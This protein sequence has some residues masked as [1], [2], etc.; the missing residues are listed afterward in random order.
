VQ[1][2]FPTT[3]GQCCY[4]IPIDAA[5]IPLVSA[6]LDKFQIRHVWASAA[7]YEAGYNAFAELQADMSG[8]CIEQLIVEI[9]ALRGG[10]APALNWRDPD[11]DPANI[12]LSTLGGVVVETANVG[13]K[14]VLAN[15]KL[16]Q[17]KA[18]IEA[19]STDNEGI[20]QALG[21]IAVLLG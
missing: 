12:G 3:Y 20:L 16:D 13:D 2:T 11:A 9:R 17:I 6:A 5:L 7:D 8:R 19:G 1:Y 21:Q 15:Q 18:A 4:L 10:S 14:L